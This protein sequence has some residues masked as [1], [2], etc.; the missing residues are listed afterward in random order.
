M[1]GIEVANTDFQNLNFVSAG[2]GSGKTHSLIEKLVEAICDDGI[3]PDKIVAVTFTQK[4][5]QELQERLLTQVQQLGRFDLAEQLS[6]GLIGTVH[7]VCAQLLSDFAFELGLPIRQNVITD[8]EN[9]EIFNQA[10]DE[11][12]DYALLERVTQLTS[13]LINPSTLRQS[14]ESKWKS[15]VKRI[16]EKARTNNISNLTLASFA[17]S[18]AESLLAYFPDAKYRG[19]KDTLKGNLTKAVQSAVAE[20]KLSVD[21]TK[22]T[23]DYENLLR[24]LLGYLTD[25]ACPWWV[26]V[27]LAMAAPGA[28]SRDIAQKVRKAAS[29][30]VFMSEFQDDVR[31]LTKI[32]VQLAAS[33]LN[34]YSELKS[35]LGVIDF[36]DM[37]HLTYRAMDAETVAE[38]LKG[39]ID[40]VVV[41]EFQDTSPIQLAIFAKLATFAERMVFVGDVKQSIYR[42][43]EADVDLVLSTLSDILSRG[44]ST[45]RLE[46]N[47]RSNP[48]LVHLVNT[49]FTRVFDSTLKD[50]DIRLVPQKEKHTNEPG[51]IR[52]TL[53]GTN[54]VFWRCLVQ[55]VKNLVNS[56]RKYIVDQANGDN[57]VMPRKVEY[58]DIAVLVRTNNHLRSVTESFKQ[59]GVPV[60]VALPDLLSTPEITLA[61]ACLRRLNNPADSYA[62]AEIVSLS[63]SVDP[64][65]WLKDRIRWVQKNESTKIES[66]QDIV[67]NQENGQTK[68]RQ[69]DWQEDSHSMVKRLA[70][71]RER[72]ILRSPVEIV[73]YVIN[74]V[75]VRQAVSTWGPTLADSEQR[76]S[77]LDALLDLVSGYEEWSERR[78]EA[79][80]LT[81]FLVWIDSIR[82]SDLDRQSITLA[83]SDSVHVSTLHGA[84]GLEWPVVVVVDMYRAPAFDFGG[85]H[86][87]KPKTFSASEPLQGRELRYWPNPFGSRSTGIEVIDTIKDSDWGQSQ[88]SAERAETERLMYVAL[89]RAKDLVVVANKHRRGS[90]DPDASSIINGLH[91]SVARYCCPTGIGTIELDDGASIDVEMIEMDPEGNEDPV[92]P[93]FNPHWFVHRELCAHPQRFLQPSRA[94]PIKGS[95]MGQTLNFSDRLRVST[96]DMQALG[97]ALHAILAMEFIN[98]NQADRIA[99]ASE[100]LQ[101]HDIP[102]DSLDLQKVFSAIEA[103]KRNLRDQFAPKTVRL[104]CPIRHSLSN[105][106]VIAGYV[107]MLLESTNG[108]VVIDHKTN[109][110]SRDRWKGQV[111][112]YSGQLAAYRKALTASNDVHSMWLNFVV[113]GSLVEVRLPEKGT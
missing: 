16:C 92:H 89:T 93:D 34:R 33:T 35:E 61:L 107:D 104:E 69:P 65:V 110:R 98:P 37:E 40:F 41:D 55:Q 113:P 99:K 44:A 95:S 111:F 112:E 80:T 17:E 67:H 79:A 57:N 105:G 14:T 58:G 96:S 73:A 103:L 82:G 49:T 10:L 27:D 87:V 3:P 78:H 24:R 22:A 75:G 26:W 13:S 90:V 76:Q 68:Q 1:A 70:E 60:K 7:S 63:G 88:L 50:D 29:V 43:R 32:V 81:G 56:D 94:Q 46:V 21:S 106:Q 84:K 64:E 23:Q 77:N 72:N 12:P 2:A 18:S 97:Q 51:L 39:L 47:W 109:P 83:A 71:I 42:F 53:S 108:L 15:D 74:E 52:W 100:L 36:V 9:E 101:F 25:E 31:D 6:Q 28:R 5:A 86:I 102:E 8:A 62:T 66:D 4:A 85:V 20:I 59:A 38:K 45:D 11:A 54:N 91:G 30:Y 19:E 48:D